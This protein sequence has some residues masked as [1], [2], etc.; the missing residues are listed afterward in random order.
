MAVK[1]VDAE[2]QKL[3]LQAEIAALL[4]DI[5]KLTRQ[6]VEGG[7]IGGN[8]GKIHAK[9]FI[10]EENGMI[11]RRLAGILNALLKKDWLAVPDEEGQQAG[12]LLRLGDLLT[13]HHTR[14]TEEFVEGFQLKNGQNLPMLLYLMICADIID[15]SYSKGGA[16]FDKSRLDASFSKQ[17]KEF[18]YL[19]T[20]LGNLQ[21]Q[22]SWEDIEAAAFVF[23]EDLAT[24][25]DQYCDWD[26]GQL[27]SKRA[28]LL[29]LMKDRLSNALAETRLPTNDVS[30]WQHSYSTAA[31]FKAMLARH[32]LLEDYRADENGELAPHK[33]K[34]AYL[35]VRWKEDELLARAVRPKE[36]LGR[37]TEMLKTK[38]R[39]KEIVEVR[40]C[41]G[42]EV[43]QDRNGVCFLVP[44]PDESDKIQ[45]CFDDMLEEMEAFLGEGTLL[46]GDL[47]YEILCKNVGIQMLGLAELLDGDA[48]I[49]RSGPRRPKW[50][51]L[52][53]PA[54][55][56][57]EICS[58]CGLRPAP[59]VAVTAG[60]EGDEEKVCESCEILAKEGDNV[61]RLAPNSN[62][63][64]LLGAEKSSNLLTYETDQ[65]FFHEDGENKRVALIQGLFN[66]RPFLSG[67]AFSSILARRPEDYNKA[68]GKGEKSLP[69]SDWDAMLSATGSEW[70][71][72]LSGS[73]DKQ[74]LHTLRQIFQDNN[75][76]SKKDGRV[77]GSSE[78]QKLQNY[79]QQ[80][81]LNS[82]CP[83]NLD[84]A[85]KI[86]LYALRQHPAPSRLARIWETTE[87]MCR[88]SVAWCQENEVR[89]FP[90]SVDPGRF[91]VLL[92]ARRAW[93]FVRAM[94]DRYL[95][96][97]GRVRHLL[98][99]HL[100]A[101]VFYHKAPL[102]IGID[103]MRRF[104]EIAARADGPE[105]WTLEAI[106]RQNDVYALTW[107][108]H[109]GRKVQWQM[110]A[111]IPNGDPERFFTWFWVKGE[112]RPFSIEDIR[113]G[114]QIEVRPSTFDYEVLDTTARRYDIRLNQTDGGIGRPH[115]FLGDAGPRPYPLAAIEQWEAMM[116]QPAF[117]KLDPTQTNQLVNL[118]GRTHLEW[119]NCDPETFRRQTEDHLALC[120]G[121][122]NVPDFIEAAVSGAF[123]DLFEWRHFIGKQP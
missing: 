42:N 8:L 44:Q 66:L 61:R 92:P 4:H 120:L 33:E 48:E 82:P 62:R 21:N 95:E 27:I 110:P 105:W 10:S 84:D 106:D 47:K 97:A 36:I 83:R 46:K 89:Y 22:I 31:I 7:I 98:P 54:P 58:R 15:S 80:I 116:T 90:L 56:N 19:A 108:D 81:V 13:F 121:P 11:T 122:E 69:C 65:L 88:Y 52:W 112:R 119:R 53:T 18:C 28:D 30:L 40:Y 35:A 93:E 43:Y 101:S 3:M 115:M 91:L 9:D 85:Q 68:P 77:P 71:K 37:R 63:L 100:S 123:L 24:L 41:L 99:F 60:S 49:L 39:L 118:V 114:Q 102:Y 72:I 96:T 64:Q 20:P 5:G 1:G 38:N 70:E 94:Y 25:L 34:L 103:A 73:K 104:S 23:Q 111:A 45:A 78:D 32:L 76:G 55:K 86:V 17:N 14:K 113:P 74:A 50:I 51:E 75:L 26:L 29:Q 12:Q 57:K 79:I 107:T 59:L 2:F 87:K 6:F 67:E 117:Q 16:G 109:L